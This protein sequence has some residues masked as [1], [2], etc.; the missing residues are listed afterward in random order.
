MVD[1]CAS[2]Q[3]VLHS[4]RY[5]YYQIFRKSPVYFVHHHLNSKLTYAQSCMLVLIVQSY[6]RE[7]SPISTK[8]VARFVEQHFQVQMTLL[9]VRLF[10]RRHPQFLHAGHTKPI[11]IPRTNPALIV[12]CEEF[13][14]QSDALIATGRV[15]ASSLVTFDETVVGF[16]AGKWE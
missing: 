15:T 5:H 10:L 1:V 11:S 16:N 9:A 7:L 14:K 12:Y 3:L 4:V 8:E 2:Y 13:A 6:A